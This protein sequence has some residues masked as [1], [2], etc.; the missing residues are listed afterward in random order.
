MN[1]PRN[2]VTCN[3]QYFQ[4]EWIVIELDSSIQIRLQNH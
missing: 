2:L 1:F 3:I 4:L